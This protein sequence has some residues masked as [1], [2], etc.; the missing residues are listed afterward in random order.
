MRP[1]LTILCLAGCLD[2]GCADHPGDIDFD[3]L[4]LAASARGLP[5]ETGDASG[6]AVIT[7]RVLSDLTESESAVIIDLYKDPLAVTTPLPADHDAL[8]VVKLGGIITPLVWTRARQ[9]ADL[10]Y[11]RVRILWSA[12]C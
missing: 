3:E 5:I 12:G 6:I 7:R 11:R 8:I 4:C 2:L 1:I 9:I 10:G